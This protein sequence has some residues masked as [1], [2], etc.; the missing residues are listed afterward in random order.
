MGDSDKKLFSFVFS[1]YKM[2]S[3]M[4]VNLDC[5]KDVAEVDFL[6]IVQL[7]SA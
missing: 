3:K 2:A 4:V 1:E 5:R 7:P 6:V